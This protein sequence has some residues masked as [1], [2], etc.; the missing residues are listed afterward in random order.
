MVR[1]LWMVS[2][3][4]LSASVLGM[5][6]GYFRENSNRN[7]NQLSQMNPN[8][9]GGNFNQNGNSQ[10]PQMNISRHDENSN[11]NR[12]GQPLP[13]NSGH[14]GGIFSRGISNTMGQPMFQNTNFSAFNNQYEN[15][16][17]KRMRNAEEIR[18][19]QG[20]REYLNPPQNTMSNILQ[21]P[22]W[23]PSG[24]QQWQLDLLQNQVNEQ[25]NIILILVMLVDRLQNQVGQLLRQRTVANVS[26]F[27]GRQPRVPTGVPQQTLPPQQRGQ[28]QAASNSSGLFGSAQHA[29]T[30][31]QQ[32]P[33]QQQQLLQ[34]LHR[35]TQQLLQQSQQQQ[36]VSTAPDLEG[37]QSQTSAGAPQQPQQPQLKKIKKE[38]ESS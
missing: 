34:Q 18:W 20:L 26:G 10:P 37:Q 9:R 7:N 23:Q 27:G 4:V 30:S 13:T 5:N 24:S 8:Y 12:N 15:N 2:F 21:P 22:Q 38:H 17:R 31:A 16:S 14:Y 33:S 35:L 25:F 11:E 6:T 3:A 36:V 29:S 19:P 32:Y 28:Q 1:S